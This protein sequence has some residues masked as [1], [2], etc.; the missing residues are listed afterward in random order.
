MK[1]FS[2][3]SLTNERLYLQCKIKDVLAEK[4]EYYAVNAIIDTGATGSAISVG[5]A[6]KLNLISAGKIY[7]ES[8]AYNG[9][10][11]FYFLNISVREFEVEKLCVCAYPNDNI[12]FLIGMDL[13]G[14]GSFSF[15]KVKEGDILHGIVIGV[16]EAEVALDLG[17]YAEGIIK[18][19]ELSN[20]P[21]FSIKAD[22]Q[23]LSF[24]VL[25]VILS[26]Q[27]EIITFNI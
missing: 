13:L 20:D 10:V 9:Y 1:K 8:A 27:S 23:V 3:Q 2:I 4:E 18:L 7:V 17:Y 24:R 25:Y 14:Q 5:L 26:I 15:K 12:G 11:D 19:E 16:T 6:E 22:I 21:R